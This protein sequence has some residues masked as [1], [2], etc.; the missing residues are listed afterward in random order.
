MKSFPLECGR[1]AE[2]RAAWRLLLAVPVALGAA[3]A[4]AAEPPAPCGPPAPGK[5]APAPDKAS[6]DRAAELR[7]A[8]QRVEADLQALTKQ[9]LDLEAKKEKLI[10]EL[11]AWEEAARQKENAEEAARLRDSKAA[12]PGA[13][14]VAR[15]EDL[16]EEERRILAAFLALD[17]AQK[18]E[19]LKAV[20]PILSRPKVEADLKR[21]EVELATLIEKKR[22][23]DEASRQAKAAL[24]EKIKDVEMQLKHFADDTE[25]LGRALPQQELDDLKKQVN[26]LKAENKQ[27]KELLAKMQAASPNG[28][29]LA[30]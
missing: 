26:D 8:L 3:W 16:T 30:P 21:L 23:E 18:E 9:Q 20:P 2:R 22:A 19:E 12:R 6:T 17:A 29:P 14:R 1:P 11:H 5:A 27:L 4:A 13:Q 15:L 25:R 24:E 7:A 10:L 28:P